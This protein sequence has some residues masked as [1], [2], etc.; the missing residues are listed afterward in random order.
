MPQVKRL[1]ELTL[2]VRQQKTDGGYDG[3]LSVLQD[4]VPISAYLFGLLFFE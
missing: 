2:P 3:P 1:K 4:C